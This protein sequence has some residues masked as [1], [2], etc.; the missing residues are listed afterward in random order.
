M[1]KNG[2]S[3]Y[4]PCKE[5]KLRWDYGDK[6]L[7]YELT[8]QGCEQIVNAVGNQLDEDVPIHLVQELGLLTAL[9]SS[10]DTDSQTLVDNDAQS[11]VDRITYIL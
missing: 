9:L 11:L 1:D 5:S 2:A 4:T 10:G 8:K 6:L 7:Y 3:S